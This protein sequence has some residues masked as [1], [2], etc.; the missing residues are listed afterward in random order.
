MVGRAF[1]HGGAHAPGNG[2]SGY[3]ISSTPV[4]IA[5]PLAAAATTGLGNNPDME[6]AA[7]TLE[8]AG[9]EWTQ[10]RSP[11]SSEMRRDQAGDRAGAAGPV[12]LRPGRL[13]AGRFDFGVGNLV[14]EPRWPETAVRVVSW[15][16][17]LATSALEKLSN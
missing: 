6:F 10:Q 13:T 14:L 17:L 16:D 12:N 15:L 7:Q 11:G 9:I 5:I 8:A 2:S 4:G 1:V 3:R